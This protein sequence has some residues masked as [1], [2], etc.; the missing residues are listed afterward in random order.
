[1]ALI[2]INRNPT[3][4]Q[5]RQFGMICLFI[6]PLLGWFWD[7]S[8]VVVGSLATLGAITALTALARPVIV[9]PLFVGLTLITAPIGIVVGEL[10][11]LLIYLSVFLPIGLIFRLAGQDALQ[12]NRNRTASTYW[13][14][15][16]LSHSA[17]RYF[18]QS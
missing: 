3:H 10:T 9:K 15:K 7:G 2:E 14:P 8:S 13:Q 17:R 5:L 16:Q 1:M 18:R 11:L 12:L 6:L 4:R